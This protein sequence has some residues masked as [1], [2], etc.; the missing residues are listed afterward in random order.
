[1][2][3]VFAE[4][5][6]LDL[7]ETFINSSKGTSLAQ[8]E[9]VQLYVAYQTKLRNMGWADFEGLSWLAA[10]T[11]RVPKPDGKFN[12]I[13]VVDGFYLHRNTKRIL[14]LLEKFTNLLITPPA[15]MSHF[16]ELHIDDLLTPIPLCKNFHWNS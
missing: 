15:G 2:Q 16:P 12:A 13:L 5:K 10:A 11:G 4:L 8:Q 7:P 3:D 6:R 1:M 9:L 14:Q